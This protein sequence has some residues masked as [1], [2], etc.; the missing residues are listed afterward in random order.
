MRGYLEAWRIAR[1]EF[2]ADLCGQ[3]AAQ[4]G[5]RWNHAGHPALYLGLTPAIC[6][7]ECLINSG[8]ASR[9]A[10]KLVRIR[11]P[12]APGLY[13]QPEQEYLPAG[14]NARP[15]DIASRDF[16]TR[17][18]QDGQ[19]LGLIVPSSVLP[20]ANILLLNPLHVAMGQVEVMEIC[21]FPHH[22]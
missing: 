11:L 21:G 12:Q 14:W 2:V 10:L 3:Y 5:A 15:A 6:A 18:L 9:V 19:Q 4:Y 1:P 16:G 17:W 13:C 7:L 20:Q 22:C 8:D